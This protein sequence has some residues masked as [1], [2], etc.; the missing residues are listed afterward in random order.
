MDARVV[1]NVGGTSIKVSL[2]EDQACKFHVRVLG[3]GLRSPWLEENSRLVKSDFADPS[4]AIAFAAKRII[5]AADGARLNVRD[6]CYRI[7]YF[8]PCPALFTLDNVAIEEIESYKFLQVSHHP[9]LMVAINEFRSAFPYARHLA[10]PDHAGLCGTDIAAINTQLSCELI[11][12]TGAFAIPQ[13]GYAIRSAIETLKSLGDN[14]QGD[15]L[16]CHVGSGITVS[17]LR[18]GQLVWSSMLY[19][20]CDGPLM[21]Y[22]TGSLPIGILLRLVRAGGDR[23]LRDLFTS[24]GI[25]GS[26]DENDRLALTLAEVI[27][28]PKYAKQTDT[29]VAS[30]A[31][32]IVGSVLSNGFPDIF[33]FAGNMLVRSERLFELII[34]KLEMIFCRRTID[35]SKDCRDNCSEW[36]HRLVAIDEEQQISSFVATQKI[37]ACDDY[38]VRHLDVQALRFSLKALCSDTSALDT[39]EFSKGGYEA[40]YVYPWGLKSLFDVT[41]RPTVLHDSPSHVAYLDFMEGFTHVFPYQKPCGLVTTA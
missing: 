34:A 28:S 37:G 11:R 4:E 40:F 25:Y 31:S 33:V 38:P 10:V 3:F 29:Y 35:V 18:S 13:H 5:S 30:I 15:T 32:A 6:I 24:G 14:V 27:D 41:W 21:T 23:Y 7:K 9:A 17:F 20:S 26:V 19:S 8:R 2:F 12:R 16:V 39:I 22:R 1:V 36:P